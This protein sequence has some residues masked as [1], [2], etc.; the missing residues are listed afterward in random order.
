MHLDPTR[1]LIDI[2]A[3]VAEIQGC[4]MLDEVA[5]R[6]GQ[7]VKTVLGVDCV[8]VFTAAGKVMITNNYVNG[9]RDIEIGYS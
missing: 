9:R 4:T 7:T 5:Q 1:L 2:D 8:E 6:L 3:V